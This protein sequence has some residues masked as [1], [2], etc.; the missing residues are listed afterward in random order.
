M[1]Y[2]MPSTIDETHEAI[3]TQRTVRALGGCARTRERVARRGGRGGSNGTPTVGQLLRNPH[4]V[5]GASVQAAQAVSR[6]WLVR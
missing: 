2:A 6:R 5:A 3:S 1:I 4:V